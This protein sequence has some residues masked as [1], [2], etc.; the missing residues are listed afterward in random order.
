MKFNLLLLTATITPSEG[1]PFLKRSDPSIRLQDYEK[2]LKFYLPLLNKCIDSIIFAENSN[3]DISNLRD[4]VNQAG[5]TKQVE[6]IVFDGLD[7]PPHYDRAYG[8][9]KLIDYVMNHSQLIHKQDQEIIVWKVTGRYIISN[10]GKIISSKPSNFDIYCN[11]RKIPKPWAEMYLI[12]WT[13]KGYQACLKN[14]YHQ[15]KPVMSGEVRVKD[16]EEVFIDLLEQVAKDIY[17]VPRFNLT[18][19]VNGVR[20]WTNENFLEG[21]NFYKYY[22]RSVACKLFP[23]LW[24]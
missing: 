3:S 4:L 13:L 10:L 17:L 21:R 7:Y 11:F 18:P 22:I 14:I 8:E 24:I 5:A 2:A 19:Q 1:V 12:A 20:G 15:L 16:P 6:F 9:F 23:W